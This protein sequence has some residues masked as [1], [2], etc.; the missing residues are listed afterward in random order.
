MREGRSARVVNRKKSEGD[1]EKYDR[2]EVTRR[3]SDVEEGKWI[4]GREKGHRGGRKDEEGQKGR[5]VM[6]KRKKFDR[7]RKESECLQARSWW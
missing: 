7:R 2:I 1:L 5:P 4:G 6:R 3:K